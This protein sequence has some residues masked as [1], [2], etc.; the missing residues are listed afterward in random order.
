MASPGA[1]GFLL[2][3]FTNATLI[4]EAAADA[5]AE[6][7][8]QSIEI[9]M[10]GATAQTYKSITG[11]RASYRLF[12][13]GVDLL[14]QRG[15]NVKLKTMLMTLNCHEL[16]AMQVLAESLGVEFRYDPMLNGAIDGGHTPVALRLSPEEVL[17]YDLADPARLQDLRSL[18][19]G[20]KG[21]Q[22]DDRLLYTCGAGQN[23][24]HVD[25]FG[26][27]S[28]C[29]MSRSQIFDLRHNTFK[30][31]WEQFLPFLRRQPA[32]GDNTCAVCEL[33]PMCGQ[34]PG[35]AELESGNPQ[36]KVNYLC[37]VAHLRYNALGQ[38]SAVIPILE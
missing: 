32:V 24:F 8:P 34:C 28:A 9:T 27:L 1:K 11:Q 14:L 38:D 25:P 31:G 12:R 4:D 20:F 7:P 10:Y 33:L 16:T 19:D 13:R 21:K 29:I 3:L 30:E 22:A 6:M 17:R 35:W 23:T 26:R 15:L 2:T 5:L 36:Q 37:Q 18:M